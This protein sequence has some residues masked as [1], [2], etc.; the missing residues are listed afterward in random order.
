[1]DYKPAFSK[2]VMTVKEARELLG[3][4]ANGMT[5]IEIERLIDDLDLIARYALKQ[6]RQ[7]ILNRNDQQEI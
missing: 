3:D 7:D 2:P 5:D 6:A 4:E 1:M